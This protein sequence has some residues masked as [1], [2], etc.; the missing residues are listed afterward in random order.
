MTDWFETRFR[1]PV[2]PGRPDPG[3]V[4]RMRAL[5][6]E[7]WQADSGMLPFWGPD[8]DEEEG[9]GELIM[10][11]TEDRPA[12]NSASPGPRWP[13]RWLLVAAAVAVVAVA[14][15][16]VFV[17]N[18]ENQIDTATPPST[19]EPARDLMRR[20][21]FSALAPGRYYL[22]PDNDGT[23][24]MR[25]TYQLAT[26]GWDQWFGALKPVAGGD[27]YTGFSITTV[28]NL[29]TDACRDHT[30]LVPPVGPTVD[31]L[32]AALSQL[33]PFELTEPPTDVS[34]FGYSGKRLVLTVPDLRVGGGENYHDFADC[35]DGELHSWISP[36]N[37][38]AF[39]G[40]EGPG[41]T[42]EFLILDVD[43]TRLVLVRNT[44]PE[45][46]ALD[47]AE[48]DAI[49]DSIRIEPN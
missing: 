10:L 27:G 26:E 47:I 33:E 32:A 31:D 20:P 8:R 2:D 41:H 46:P 49:F 48:R 34:R 14:G 44:H 18:D 11:E 6:V 9:E 43:G 24:P 38:G 40:Y 17:G 7:E 13:H 12:G 36:L 29:V 22:D 16:L 19:T 30:P 5:V 4:A 37:G 45:S 23:T 21:N 15:T 25:V 3:F 1:E 39:Y 35:V 28:P 42:E